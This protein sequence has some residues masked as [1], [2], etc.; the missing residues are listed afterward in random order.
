MTGWILLAN[1]LL[2]T[3]LTAQ[4]KKEIDM[5]SETYFAPSTLGIKVM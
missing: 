1:N 3:N 5:K 2:V 4:F